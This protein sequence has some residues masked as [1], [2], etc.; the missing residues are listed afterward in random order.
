MPMKDAADMYTPCSVIGMIGL[1]D[2]REEEK[3]RKREE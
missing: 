3:M 1:V 2:G